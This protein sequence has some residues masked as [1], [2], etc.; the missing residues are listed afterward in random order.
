MRG[1]EEQEARRSPALEALE[2]EGEG[3]A[4]GEA[5][6]EDQGPAPALPPLQ[7]HL[8]GHAQH[9][10]AEGGQEDEQRRAEHAGKKVGSHPSCTLRGWR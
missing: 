3:V 8:V 6:Q 10:D 9:A 5:V 1:E 7:R 2:E 4:L